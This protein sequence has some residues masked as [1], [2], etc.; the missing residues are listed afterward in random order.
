MRS[1]MFCSGR[2]SSNEDAWPLWLLR[3]IGANK[4]GE[5]NA[6]R[7][8]EGPRSWRLA[9]AGV[10]IRCVCRGCNNGWMSQLETRA[11]PVIEPLLDDA[12]VV[13]SADDQ[14]TLAIWAIKSAMVYE[15]LRLNQSWVFTHEERTRLRESLTLPPRTKVWI[16]KCVD[17]PG[18]YCAASDLSGKAYASGHPVRAYVTTMAFGPLAIQVVNFRLASVIPLSVD[19]TVDLGAGPWDSLATQVWPDPR[20][21]VSWPAT[22]GL[23]GEAGLEAFSKRWRP[24]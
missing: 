23:A 15:G 3:Q 5:V 4:P 21:Q 20:H 11:K 14:T 12:A 6:E 18:P 9:R 19:I 16:A 7:G 13:L 2:V 17:P 8:R 24:E 22:M 10:L 1:C